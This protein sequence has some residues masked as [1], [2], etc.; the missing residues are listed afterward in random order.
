MAGLVI[1]AVSGEG[2]QA[3]AQWG[4][5]T[6]ILKASVLRPR[7]LCLFELLSKFALCFKLKCMGAAPEK[8][9]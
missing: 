4:L 7:R 6:R 2:W 9:S 3:V 1:G 5:V 8:G